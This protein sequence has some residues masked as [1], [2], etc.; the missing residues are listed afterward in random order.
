MRDTIIFIFFLGLNVIFGPM[1]T[2]FYKE[3]SI[4]S[5]EI[6]KLCPNNICFYGIQVKLIYASFCLSVWDIPGHLVES[7][8][9]L[10]LPLLGYMVRWW[11]SARKRKEIM[12]RNEVSC[13]L[14]CNVL[15]GFE[16]SPLGI[17][18]T[19]KGR[20]WE[21]FARVFKSASNF[22]HACE[23]CVIFKEEN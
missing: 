9:L 15:L 14:S 19:C 21:L 5:V 22:A 6:R 10:L 2:N 3:Q 16:F 1:N 20:D 23:I 17:N 13:L 12:R 11:S 7:L 18:E 4:S 8:I